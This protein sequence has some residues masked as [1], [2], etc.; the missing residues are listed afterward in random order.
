MQTGL[1]KELR[2]FK[3]PK[4]LK[5]SDSNVAGPMAKSFLGE[6]VHIIIMKYLN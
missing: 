2:K 1:Q 6:F 5:D 4:I 3:F